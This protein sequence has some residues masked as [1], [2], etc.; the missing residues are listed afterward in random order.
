MKSKQS[1]GTGYLIGALIGFVVAISAFVLTEKM[2][3]SI[4]LLAGLA[5]PL[6]MVFEQKF[7][8]K[9]GKKDPKTVKL[10]MSLLAVGILLFLAIL[11]IVKFL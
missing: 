8:V 1:E 11:F 5:L 3:I 9:E 4:A 7:Q 6:G 10:L 2:V